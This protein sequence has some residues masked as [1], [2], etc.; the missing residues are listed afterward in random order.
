[1]EQLLVL[2]TGRVALHV[3]E[4]LVEQ[5]QPPV[6]PCDLRFVELGLYLAQGPIA[7]QYEIEH[8]ALAGTDLLGHVGNAPPRGD[9]KRARIHHPLPKQHLEK[10]GLARTVAA[11]QGDLLA[12]M[13][14]GAGAAEEG[15]GA[16]LE[17]D[18]VE[19]NHGAG[20]CPIQRDAARSL[21]STDGAR[22]FRARK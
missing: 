17:V 13:D 19:S 4:P 16:P 5:G 20:L 8:R 11:N 10:T 14:N 7:I 22:G 21:R 1:M 15:I 2:N 3:V 9:G 6:I 18:L 12:G